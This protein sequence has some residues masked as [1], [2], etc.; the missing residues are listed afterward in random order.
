[1]SSSSIPDA[2]VSRTT[3]MRPPP[4]QIPTALPSLATSSGVSVSPTTPRTPS[5]PKYLRAAGARS[6]LKE[7]ALRELRRLARLVQAG[8]LALADASVA[9]EEARTLQ[10]HAQPRIGLDQRARDPVPDRTGLAA[11][12]AAVNPHANVVATL[13]VRHPERR[14]SHL[15]VDRPREVLLDRPPVEPGAAVARPQDHSCDRRLP[16]ARAEVLRDVRLRHRR[17]SRGGGLGACA[18]WGCSGPA[19]IFS[20]VFCARGSRFRGSMPLTAFRSTSVGRRSSC[21]RSGRDRSPPGYP[22]CRE[23]ILASA[24]LPVTAIFS[25]FTTMTKSPVSTCGV[26]CGLFLPRSRSAI[27]VASRPRVWPSASTTYHSRVISPGLA[28]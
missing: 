17:F 4:D 7:L 11:R 14:Q 26:Y 23:D 24:F 21:S 18:S 13:E 1:A 12:A 15:A 20:F 5:V 6:P 3:R 2:R 27:C 19:E 28:L 25:A 8:L 22:E 16:L 9:R 10:R